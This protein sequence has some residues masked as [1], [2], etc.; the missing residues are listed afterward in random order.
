MLQIELVLGAHGEVRGAHAGTPELLPPRSFRRT[1][2][3]AARMRECCAWIVREDRGR[4]LARAG[5]RCASQAQ[6]ELKRMY[7]IWLSALVSNQAPLRGLALQARRF[8]LA[9][10]SILHFPR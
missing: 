6:E 10:A 3:I 1:D 9:S 2:R 5:R 8:C 7:T 4:P